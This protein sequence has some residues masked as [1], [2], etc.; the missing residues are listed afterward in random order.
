M[1]I[2]ILLLLG[3]VAWQEM[4]ISSLKA[5]LEQAQRELSTRVE[6]TGERETPEPSR[7]NGRRPWRLSTICIDRRRACSGP[8]ALHPGRAEGRC[9]SDRH[10]GS[11]RLHA[12]AHRGQVGRR[13]AAIDRRRHQGLRR[14]AAQTPEVA[15][16]LSRIVQ[17]M[18]GRQER[19]DAAAA[20][21]VFE[22]ER[23]AS[24]RSVLRRRASDLRN[25][26]CGRRRRSR[27]PRAGSPGSSAPET[28][29]ARH[30][31]DRAAAAGCRCSRERS[32]ASARSRAASTASGAAPARPGCRGLGTGT[33]AIDERLGLRVEPPID[34]RQVDRERHAGERIARILAEQQ[35]R[36]HRRR[37]VADRLRQSRRRCDRSRVPPSTDSAS[38]VRMMNRDGTRMKLKPGSQ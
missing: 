22:L 23:A 30:T 36:D 6:R 21:D 28:R 24:S 17:G 4:R 27:R 13:G 16:G 34:G 5:D 14:M 10:V 35:R 8:A 11:G 1:A 19:I 31:A 26:R 12:G 20:F 25:L 3:Q 29:A 2:V 7:G 9:R 38:I 37:E 18:S 15:S 32:S 33:S